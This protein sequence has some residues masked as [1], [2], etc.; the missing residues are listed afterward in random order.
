MAELADSTDHS[1]PEVMDLLKRLEDLHHLTLY[2]EIV[3]S[4]T[5][6]SMVHPFSHL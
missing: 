6:I 1:T 5:P 2:K 4:P 3:P